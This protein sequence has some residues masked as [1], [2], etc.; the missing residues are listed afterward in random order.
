VLDIGDGRIRE[1]STFLAM[2]HAFSVWG[3]PPHLPVPEMA[4]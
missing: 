1:I 2:A 4:D 3:L